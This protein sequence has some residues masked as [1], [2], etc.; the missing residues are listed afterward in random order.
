MGRYRFLMARRWVIVGPPFSFMAE[1]CR[2]HEWKWRANNHSTEGHQKSI[3]ALIK[4]HY[5]YYYQSPV[6]E[7]TTTVGL[8]FI[9]RNCGSSALKTKH[10]LSGSVNM[11]ARPFD[12]YRFF[13]A[14]VKLHYLTGNAPM[15]DNIMHCIIV[16]MKSQMY[17]VHS[18]YTSMAFI[19]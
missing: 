1:A 3:N 5:Y 9:P 7:R 16:V 2:G 12:N 19:E 4:S 17:I 6:K 8:W 13:D 11:L 10:S 18:Y 15:T 14:T